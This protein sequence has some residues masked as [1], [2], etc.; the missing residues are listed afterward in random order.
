MKKEQYKPGREIISLEG[1]RKILVKDG[2]VYLEK[3]V[4]SK[5]F[6]MDLPFEYISKLL[7]QGLIRRVTK[8]I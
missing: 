7:D 4:H 8:K 6:V 3:E 2:V 1:L 5:K